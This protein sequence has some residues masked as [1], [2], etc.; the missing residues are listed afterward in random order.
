MSAQQATHAT[1]DVFS[2]QRWVTFQGNP[3]AVVTINNDCQL[4]HDQ[5]QRI[6]KEF[7][8]TETV[9][10]YA[11]GENPRVEIF[12]PIDEMAFAG[13][14]IIGTGHLLF[15][16]SAADPATQVSNLTITT[17]AGPVALAYDRAN[18]LVHATVPQNFHVHQQEA[19][20]D[21][22]RAVQAGMDAASDLFAV[23]HTHPVVSMVS[24]VTYALVDLTRRHDIFAGIVPGASPTLNLDE[25]WSPSFTGV[26]YY[27]LLDSHLEA[28]SGM[29]HWNLRVRMVAI[30]LEDPAC[31]SG[32]CSLS[33][34][35]ALSKGD[36]S[37][38]HRFNISQGSEMGRDSQIV[39]DVYL[40]EEGRQLSQLR[41]AGQA[42]VVTEGRIFLS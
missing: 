25:G 37:R 3:V 36:Q 35:L 34:Y 4:S 30:N 5:K 32:G 22:I 13:H 19:T 10:L 26:M 39:V 6:A 23:K 7:N 14:P 20:L 1:L 12:T 16:G 42:T 27:R 17:K 18:L 31:G 40:D 2:K 9:Y 41:L 29:M 11:R 21:Q 33:S 24:G 15:Q 38:K 28:A 8:Y